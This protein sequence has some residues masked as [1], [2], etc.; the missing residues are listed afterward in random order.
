[1]YKKLDV[2]IDR[3]RDLE[4]NLSE[5]QFK[6]VRGLKTF[7]SYCDPDELFA[8][9]NMVFQSTQIC[10]GITVSSNVVKKYLFYFKGYKHQT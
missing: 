5:T 8:T 4:E 7:I 6:E 9:T 3:I 10:C 2:F 1:M